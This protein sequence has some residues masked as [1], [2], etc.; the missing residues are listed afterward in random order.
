M[1]QRVSLT[2]VDN[3]SRHS[4]VSCAREAI[5]QGHYQVNSAAVEAILQSQSWVP[6]LVGNILLYT[7]ILAHKNI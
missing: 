5:Y 1:S 2:R 4:K 7:F 6:N 3:A